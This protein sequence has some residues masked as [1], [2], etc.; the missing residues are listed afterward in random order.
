M[1]FS[2]SEI[3]LA[4]PE[5]YLTAALC[6]VL[7]FDLFFAEKNPGRTATFTLL[8]L[9]VGAVANIAVVDPTARRTITG[10]DLAS[11]SGNTPYAGMDLPG[12]VVH[13]LYAGTPTVI[14]GALA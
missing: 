3:W 1:T 10:A 12:R 5:I 2:S 13:T 4:L 9:V 6:V 11:K 14:D 7:L 8:V